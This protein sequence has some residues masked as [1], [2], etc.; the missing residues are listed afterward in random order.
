MREEI[1]LR[2]AVGGLA[3]GCVLVLVLMLIV[4]PEAAGL[5]AAA[6]GM[7]AQVYWLKRGFDRESDE[8]IGFWLIIG[9]LIPVY[10]WVLKGFSGAL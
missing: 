3:V 8:S 6:A 1:A 4:P 7:V 2:T 9:G 5:A 10:C